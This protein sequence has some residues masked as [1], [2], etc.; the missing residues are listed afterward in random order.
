MRWPR[1]PFDG[2]YARWA[3]RCEPRRRTVRDHRIL[4]AMGNLS[5]STPR[6]KRLSSV[7]TQS[8]RWTAAKKEVLGQFKNNGAEWQTKGEAIEVNVSDFLSLVDGKAIPSGIYD[9]IHHHGFVNV[10]IDHDTAE[11]AVES[12]RR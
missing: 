5:T 4:T 3:A 8:S 10:G 6:A 9:L 11:F 12:I 1:P 2:L 7:E